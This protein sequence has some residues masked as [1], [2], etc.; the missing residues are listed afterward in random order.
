MQPD[1]SRRG[2]LH[3]SGVRALGGQPLRTLLRR[4][5]GALR[6][7]LHRLYL[8]PQLNSGVTVRRSPPPRAA[9]HSLPSPSPS[10]ST[11]PYPSASPSPS[12]CCSLLAP[13]SHSLILLLAPDLLHLPF[14]LAACT[15]YLCLPAACCFLLTQLLTICYLA[16]AACCL[17]TCC[18]LR[19]VRR[20]VFLALL[21]AT[22]F[23]L[24]FAR[25]VVALRNPVRV[26]VRVR[27]SVRVRVRAEL[28][29]TLT[30]TLSL[31]RTR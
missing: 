13:R 27:V 9:A 2:R 6:P 21:H 15:G 11:S 16:P 3:A 7:K 28:T 12:R 30:L 19:Q 4:M 14:A 31:T 10:P 23:G 25:R 8:D 18:V 29:L 20:N 26:R 22:S 1:L 24:A 17:A 5:S